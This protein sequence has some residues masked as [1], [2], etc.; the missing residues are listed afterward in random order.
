MS[1]NKV[2]KYTGL[3]TKQARCKSWPV[4]SKP[5]NPD[6]LLSLIFLTSKIVLKE[7]AL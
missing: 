5:R 1:Y 2:I 4:T 3:R 6:K 7:E